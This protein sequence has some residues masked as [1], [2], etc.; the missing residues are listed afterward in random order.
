MLINGQPQMI[1]R[2]RALL[3]RSRQPVA[4]LLF[5]AISRK[6]LMAIIISK[7]NQN[8]RRIEESNFNLEDNLQEYVINNPEIIPVA[9]PI[10][11]Q[12]KAQ[13]SPV[14]II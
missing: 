10:F 8:A 14:K 6:K 13:V 12:L 3:F 2:A 5:S 11:V 1:S 7:N 4:V 9:V